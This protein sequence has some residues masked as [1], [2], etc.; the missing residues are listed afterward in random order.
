MI[1]ASNNSSG[2]TLLTPKCEQKSI[3]VCSGMSG[4]SCCTPALPMKH[5]HTC[6][7][8]T[9]AE[10]SCQQISGICETHRD[11]GNPQAGNDPGDWAESTQVEWSGLKVLVIDEPHQDG[12]AVCS[13]SV[14]V[15]SQH[16]DGTLGPRAPLASTM[17]HTVS[18]AHGHGADQHHASL[19]SSS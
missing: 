11:E 7:P 8:F 13:T 1:C 16:S 12:D 18:S 14:S 19:P 3:S 17:M 5:G 10:K 2:A 15:T 6:I 4:V 9:K